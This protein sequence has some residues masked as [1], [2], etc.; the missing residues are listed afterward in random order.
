MSKRRLR[1]EILEKM[2]QLATAGFGLVAALAWNSAIQDL[3]K[4]VNVF[5]SP[6]GLVVK[7]V[8]AAVVT[9]I[10]VFVTITI[11]R[12]INKLKDQLGIV[13]EGDQDKK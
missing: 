6:D 1:L 3:F 5:G 13:P 9:I 2:A 12:S 8:Y 10:V 11:G 4:K 7:F